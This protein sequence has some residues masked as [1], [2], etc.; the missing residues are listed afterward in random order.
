LGSGIPLIFI[1]FIFLFFMFSTGNYFRLSG[2]TVI[3]LK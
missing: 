1:F 2:G 3:Y